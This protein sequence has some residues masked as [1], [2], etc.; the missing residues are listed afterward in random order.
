[1]LFKA[2]TGKTHST[3]VDHDRCV[4]IRNNAKTRFAALTELSIS[5][6][7]PGD[8]CVNCAAAIAEEVA[9]VGADDE[10]TAID[11]DHSGNGS[12]PVDD[13]EDEDEY[14]VDPEKKAAEEKRLGIQ[15]A[16]KAIDIWEHLA[17][18]A[19]SVHGRKFWS[20]KARELRDAIEFVPESVQSEKKGEEET[21]GAE[22]AA[23][24]VELTVDSAEPDSKKPA[25]RRK[26]VKKATS[27]S[28]K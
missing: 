7:E 20:D 14:V 15:D 13:W 17:G 16:E 27:S 19:T 28:A 6:Y 5:D 11:S 25:S 8:D 9:R 4:F 10:S 3:R 1:M 23:A 22:G 2:P 21:A 12:D 24:D 18:R 26:P